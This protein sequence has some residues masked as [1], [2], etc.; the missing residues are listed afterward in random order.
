M[1]E[2]LVVDNFSGSWTDFQDGDINS[3]R[4][5]SGTS[6][7]ANPFISAGK[8]TWNNAP[9]QIDPTGSVITDLIVDGKERVESGIMYVYAIG[10][11][12]RLYKIQVNDPT[13]YNPNYDNPVL[14]ATLTSNSPTFTRGGF[15]DFFGSTERIY[16]GHDKG[17]TRVN[18]DGTSETFV[19]VLGSWTQDVPRPLKQFVGSLFIGNGT[20]LAQIDSTATVITYTKFSPNF[21]DNTQV[22]D[23][24]VSPDGTYLHTVVSRLALNSILS[25]TQTAD[26]SASSDSYIFKW[27]GVDTGYTA[28]NTFS[29][30]SLNANTIYGDFQYTFGYNLY[31]PALYNPTRQIWS[32]VGTESPSPNAISS[33]GNLLTWMTPVPY[34]GVMEADLITMGQYTVEIGTDASFWDQMF[35]N[36]ISPETDI[37]QVPYCKTI[38]NT[39]IGAS[40]NGYANNLFSSSKMYFS[41]L[42]TS[43]APTTAY[44]FYKWITSGIV[45]VPNDNPLRNTNA[46]FYQ[47]QSQIFSKKVSLKE[48]R[49]YA[50]P[51]VANNEFSIDIIGSSGGAIT[52]ASKTFTAGSNLTIGDDFAWYTPDAAPTYAIGL[53]V[54]NSGSANHFIDKIEIDYV[55]G[56]K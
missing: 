1:V 9:I 23:I 53:G 5:F 33:N 18:F 39:G 27:N 34:N 2:T 25:T 43:S 30:F 8:L 12:G 11:T 41:T 13:T 54:S 22:R 50:Q 6:G 15:I 14:L 19:G 47:T 16:I 17:V 45:D 29:S 44:R 32:L 31:G 36:A 46:P 49:I 20:N 40:S 26:R 48:I 7:G 35:L 37:V 24:D 51:W 28:Y 55:D 3:G 56:G 38:S 42:E 52:G 21:G 4:S 10:H